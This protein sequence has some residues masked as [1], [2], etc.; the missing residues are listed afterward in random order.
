MRHNLLKSQNTLSISLLLFPSHAHSF[1][2]TGEI[3][4]VKT[5]N[6]EESSL[7][8][9]DSRLSVG[10]KVQL[11]ARAHADQAVSPVSDIIIAYVEGVEGEVNLATDGE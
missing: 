4:E 2:K 9:K 11:Y 6:P 5:T 7:V 10:Q 1:L 8:I 3:R